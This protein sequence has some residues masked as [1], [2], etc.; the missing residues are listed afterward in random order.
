[1]GATSGGKVK[2]QQDSVAAA[3]PCCVREEDRWNRQFS[4][5]W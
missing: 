1:M 3:A 5:R 4:W 2:A